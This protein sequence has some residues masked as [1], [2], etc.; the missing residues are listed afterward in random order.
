MISNDVFEKIGISQEDREY[1]LEMDKVYGCKA[2]ELAERYNAEMPIKP[3][4]PYRGEE[5]GDASIRARKYADLAIEID[6]EKQYITQLL[7]WLYMF[8]YMEEN[9]KKY[10][11]PES[12]LLDTAANIRYKMDECM[13]VYGEVGVFVEYFFLEDEL[14]LFALG[15]LQFEYHTFYYQS[16]YKCGDFVLD[17]GDVVLACHIP[18]DGRPLSKELCMESFKMAYDFFKKDL[19]DGILPLICTS[20]MMYPP[21][22]EKVLPEK[23]N[24]KKFVDMFDVIKVFESPDRFGDS[25]RIFGGKKYEGTT[26]GLPSNNT[27]QRNMINYI[28]EGG[29]FG[30]GGGVL[31]FDG[32]KI[33]NR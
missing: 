29:K 17:E 24:I 26:E 6:P 10:N 31:L 7:M 13:S 8:S 11:I 9:Y 32:E 15:R 12:V 2:K 20:W 23:S 19:K 33:I 5:R 14:K 30:Y 21:Y 27:L 18:T 22:V 25:W 3:F 28:N 16:D 4:E 1:I